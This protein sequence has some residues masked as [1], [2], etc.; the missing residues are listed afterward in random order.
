MADDSDTA[1]PTLTEADLAVL[2][3]LGDVAPVAAGEYLYREGDVTY[4]FNVVVSGTIEIVTHDGAEEQIVAQHGPG[5]VPRGA[6]PAHRHARSS[7]PP[8]SWSPAR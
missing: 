7:C 2:D 1:F 4:D 3:G 5:Q 8:A 6:Q